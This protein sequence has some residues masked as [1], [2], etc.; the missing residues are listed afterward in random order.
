MTVDVTTTPPFDGHTGTFRLYG[1][2]SGFGTAIGGAEDAKVTVQ[3]VWTTE[4]TRFTATA[5]EAGQTL[6]IAL[7]TTGT[8]TEWDN[9]RLEVAGA[10]AGTPGTLVFGR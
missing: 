3:S 5:A 6:G 2:T 8:Q 1:S 10:S 9:V 7:S 4:T